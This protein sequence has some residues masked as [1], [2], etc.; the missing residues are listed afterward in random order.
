MP[1]IHWY[2]PPTGRGSVDDVVS[3][4]VEVYDALKKHSAEIASDARATLAMAYHRP[5][6]ERSYI[7]VIDA[8][9]SEFGWAPELDSTVYLAAPDDGGNGAFAAPTSI[10]RKSVV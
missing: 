2:G 3:H 9:E 1:K 7:G 4:T 5:E 10:D 6:A 8:G